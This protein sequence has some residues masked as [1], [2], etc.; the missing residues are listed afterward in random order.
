MS[1]I[2]REALLSQGQ[3]KLSPVVK[4]TTGRKLFLPQGVSP[5]AQAVERFHSFLNIQQS[6]LVK[7]LEFL[8]KN[9]NP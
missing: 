3:H 2:G 1:S 5:V 7:V 9:M 8:H 6:K 4:Q